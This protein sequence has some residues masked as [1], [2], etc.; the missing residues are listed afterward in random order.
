MS[1]VGL[2]I[3]E[4]TVSL[5]R[6]AHR[7]LHG[8]S[9]AVA[10]GEVVGLIGETGSGKS[11]IARSALGLIRAESGEIRID[12]ESVV[13]LSRR[14]LRALRR[15]GAIQYVFQD[16]LR[17]LDPDHT[18]FRSVAEGIRAQGRTSAAA[19]RERVEAALLLVGLDPALAQRTPD[20]LSGG[21]RQRVAIARAMAVNPR[22]LICDEPVSALDAASR[23]HVLDLLRELSIVHGV[24]ILLI[25]HDLG[26]LAGIADRV[27]V[28]LQGRIVESGPVA[29]VLLEPQEAYTRLLIASVPTLHG[30]GLPEAERRALRAQL[31]TIPH[32]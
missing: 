16:P 24:G 11:T 8:V 32:H 5:G 25:T 18:V 10:P 21:Q 26:S 9:L 3:S 17:S 20:E 22:I 23:I 4:L 12:G 31:D 15:R 6:P 13:G 1:A 30:E 2:E 19:L 29:D 7:I 27:A 14:Q 28:L